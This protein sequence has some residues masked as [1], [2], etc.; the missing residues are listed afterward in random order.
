MIYSILLRKKRYF[1]SRI[2]KDLGIMRDN[3]YDIFISYRRD[4]GDKYARTI[5]QALEK[6]FKVFLDF[7][8]LTDG[9]FNQRILNAIENSSVFL[10]ILSKGALDRCIN[11]RDWV[12][13]EILHANNCGC[14]IVPVTIDD[15]FEGLPPDL[16]EEIR[17]IVEPHQF[18]ELQ[19]K[20]LFKESIEKLIHD[21]IEKYVKEDDT[22]SGIE[23]HIESDV[24]C[25]L[26]KFKN[27][28][29][30]IK[31]CEDNVIH[32]K[33][34]KYKL[35]FVSSEF[36]EVR[37]SQIYT[38]PNGVTCDFLQ[39]CLFDKINEIR[40]KK[41]IE[42]LEN[43]KLSR[44]KV[45]GK[46]GFVDENGRVVIP[47]I[48]EDADSFSEGLARVKDEN[49][50][51][52]FINKRGETIIPFQWTFACSFSEGLACVEEDE[53]YWGFIDS[54]GNMV[55]PCEWHKAQSFIEGLAPVQDGVKY[56]YID[57]N[58]ELVIPCEWYE[59]EWFSE[60]LALVQ[61]GV[62]YGF[63]DKEGKLVISCEWH[64]AGYFSEGLAYVRKNGKMGFINK[65]GEIV[66]PCIWEDVRAFSEGLASVRGI[67][68]RW[69]GFINVKGDLV[70]PCKYWTPGYF[71][72]GV[73]KVRDDKFIE[74]LIDE[75]GN[76]VKS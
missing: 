27:L 8:E 40:K 50:M 65:D 70:I 64:E 76:V 48:W 56:G 29:T 60:G 49:N 47:C 2:T 31:K 3:T 12:R 52:G 25:D 37:N 62:N 58:G 18:S 23:I 19:M 20:T 74:I 36:P 68:G 45:D 42:M 44:V 69:W 72:D 17:Q 9:L 71:I 21:R 67:N 46:Y 4:G 75:K 55:I 41:E 10:L 35:D 6:R 14:H 28:M 7:D 53:Q 38:L 73:A 32:L 5:Q 57:K 54:K 34:G 13:Q 66:I 43:L 33:P 39:V 11:E 30:N 1:C 26:F 63:I 15:T 59:A 51:W 16:P 22:D 24:D 61:D